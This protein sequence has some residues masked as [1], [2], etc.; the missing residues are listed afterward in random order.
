MATDHDLIVIG[1]NYTGA[2][3]NLERIARGFAENA[4]VVADVRDALGHAGLAAEFTT[5]SDS[6]RIKREAMQKTVEALAKDIKTQYETWDK[7]DHDLGGD[8]PAVPEN[9][10]RPPTDGTNTPTPNQDPSPDGRSSPNQQSGTPTSPLP[11]GTVT[12]GGATGS[13]GGAATAPVGEDTPSSESPGGAVEGGDVATPVVGTLTGAAVVGAIYTIWKGIQ[14]GKKLGGSSA[15][16]PGT[17]DDLSVRDRIERELAS[18]KG[19]EKS[20]YDVELIAD[21]KD[22]DDILAILRGE[23]GDTIEMKLD[24]GDLNG[25]GTAEDYLDPNEPAH[26]P[27]DGM[28]DPDLTDVA[29]LVPPGDAPEAPTDDSSAGAAGGGGGPSTESAVPAAAEPLAAPAESTSAAAGATATGSSS[30]AGGIG[31]S[32]VDVGSLP[33]ASENASFSTSADDPASTVRSTAPASAAGV[34][35]MGMGAMGAQQMMSSS[36][37]GQAGSRPRVEN[38]KPAEPAAREAAEEEEKK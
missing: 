8:G 19:V 36:A 12:G 14:D 27:E 2:Y 3:Q 23:G 4:Q 10:G 5:F 38:L 7:L 33:D 34:G 28:A 35:M 18:L 24:D 13:D 20:G 22:P 6:W 32:G 37:A 30:S 25:S 21:P 11:G 29:E 9:K 31:R 17:S 15:G 16:S 1:A 26:F